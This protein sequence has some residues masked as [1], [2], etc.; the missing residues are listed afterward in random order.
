MPVDLQHD[1]VVERE[2][3]TQGT[4]DSGL[5]QLVP[6]AQAAATGGA[7]LLTGGASGLAIGLVGMGVAWWKKRQSDTALAQTVIG[8]ENAKEHLP[9]AST[10]MLLDSLSKTMD[11][12]TKTRI[13]RAKG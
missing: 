7:S 11:A 8:V 13:R 3:D 2:Q 12:T 6:L 10:K 1:R 5:E 9:P 4:R